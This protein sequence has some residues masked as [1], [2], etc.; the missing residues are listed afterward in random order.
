MLV[1]DGVPQ[2]MQYHGALLVDDGLVVLPEA[3]SQVDRAVPVGVKRLFGVPLHHLVERFGAGI[4]FDVQ[5][6]RVGRHGL[7]K[8]GV[9]VRPGDHGPAP[10]LVGQ[11]MGQESAEDVLHFRVQVGVQVRFQAEGVLEIEAPQHQHRRQRPSECIA[12]RHL[13]DVELLVRVGPEDATEVIQHGA[14]VGEDARRAR[15]G[16]ATVFVQAEHHV[17]S[18]GGYLAG[19]VFGERNAQ[20]RHGP[21]PLPVCDTRIALRAAGHMGA[22]R[23]H[24]QFFRVAQF[25]VESVQVLAGMHGQPLLVVQQAEEAVAAALENITLVPQGQRGGTVTRNGP[26][27]R[28]REPGPLPREQRAVAAGVVHANDVEFRIQRESGRGERIRPGRYF[29]SRLHTHVPAA[30]RQRP[31]YVIVVEGHERPPGRLVL[32][33]TTIRTRRKAAPDHGWT[34]IRVTG[35]TALLNQADRFRLIGGEGVDKPPVRVCEVDLSL[36]EVRMPMGEGVPLTGGLHVHQVVLVDT[37]KQSLCPVESPSALEGRERNTSHQVRV[38]FRRQDQHHSVEPGRVRGS[39]R[40]C[41]LV[42]LLAL[43]EV[44][45]REGE[46]SLSHEDRAADLVPGE[47]RHQQA[48]F[49]VHYAGGTLDRQ[50]VEGVDL[51]LAQLV[52]E[53]EVGC[54]QRFEPIGFPAYPTP[55]ET[56]FP[57]FRR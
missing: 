10:P 4:T 40:T 13:D 48:V 20:G 6:R 37:F 22:G 2:H 47:P 51:A 24:G 55:C 45:R 42:H 7:R 17:D 43:N 28:Y 1:A 32:P 49:H 26:E 31:R 15:I 54:Q 33:G 52:P 35:E 19:T 50:A 25:Q 23:R 36:Q 53:S 3:H 21:L 46:T 14:D 11:F 44:R 9:P 38:T 8:P 41:V 12:V 27:E 16:L 39:V 56:D 30:V 5:V 29:H 57:Q 34:D 18:T